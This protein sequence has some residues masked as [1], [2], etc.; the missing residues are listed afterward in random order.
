MNG[1][2]MCREV[3][4]E[5]ILSRVPAWIKGVSRSTRRQVPLPPAENRHPTLDKALQ[6]G[7]DTT[8][9]FFEPPPMTPMTH[10]FLFFQQPLG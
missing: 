7:I 3:D 8:R 9:G 4:D 5:G 1:C 2:A 6:I 10:R